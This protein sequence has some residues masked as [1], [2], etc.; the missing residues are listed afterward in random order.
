[1][2]AAAAQF[3]VPPSTLRDRLSGRVVHGTRP[4]PAPYLEKGEETQLVEYLT[5]TSKVGYDK[6]RKHVMNIVERVAK[7]KG[8]LKKDKI[9]CG[10]FWRF[11]ERNPSIS[12]R[13]VIQL[14]LS[15]SI[16]QLQR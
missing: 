6:T 16:V 5:A 14:L 10:W 9:S 15:A 4:G 3:G 2:N 13:Q 8:V 11:R 7:Y 1:V 12:L